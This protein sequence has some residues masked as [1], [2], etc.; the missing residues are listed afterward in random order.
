MS[1]GHLLWIVPVNWL[2]GV[3]MYFV[4]VTSGTIGQIIF[5]Q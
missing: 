2:A 3:G 4:L 1:Y 5:G